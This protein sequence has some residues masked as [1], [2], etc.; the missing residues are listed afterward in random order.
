MWFNPATLAEALALKTE[1]GGALQAIAGGTDLMVAQ[2]SQ[3]SGPRPALLNLNGLDE[4]RGVYHGPHGV[5]IGAVTPFATVRHATVVRERLPMLAASSAVTGALPIQNRATLGGNIMNASPA[6]D[7]PPVL[8]SYGA[9]LILNSTRGERRLPYEQF[10]DGYRH[11]RCAPDELLTAIYVPFPIQPGTT[12][13]Y[14]KVG[15]R[16][17]QAIS[18]LTL[19]ALVVWQAGRI[20][21]SA[22]GLASVAATP[23]AANRL[24]RYLLGKSRDQL[25]ANAVRAALAHDILPRDDLRSSAAYRKQVAGNLVLQA[26]AG[27]AHSLI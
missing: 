17:A 7:T 26:L 11:T 5:T 21:H 24:S 18:K 13:Y 4:L 10:H 14:R 9:Q 20:A 3:P 23:V 22:F 27:E 15:T 12:H 8:L 1:H 6:A 16:H 25:D 19:A 2:R